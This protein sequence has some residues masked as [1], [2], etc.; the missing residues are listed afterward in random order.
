MSIQHELIYRWSK[1]I[2][3]EV[4]MDVITL[5]LVYDL[6]VDEENM[7]VKF[8]FKPTVPNCPIGHKLALEVYYA[9]AQDETIREIDMEVTDY[10]YADQIN[11][12][13]REIEKERRKKYVKNGGDKNAEGSKEDSGEGKRGSEGN[14]GGGTSGS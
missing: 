6:E 13:I 11:T 8:K 9:V 14:E 3:P 7:R 2:D 10:V 5:G 4:N 12:L 1:V